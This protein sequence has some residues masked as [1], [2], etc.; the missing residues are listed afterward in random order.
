MFTYSRFIIRNTDRF[1]PANFPIQEAK[2]S[3]A[4]NAFNKLSS[5]YRTEM[6]VSFLKDHCIP[7]EWVAANRELAG[8]IS[9]KVLPLEDFEV[10]FEAGKDGPGCVQFNRKTL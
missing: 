9:S 8:M 3:F 1:D 4:K 5:V 10:L 7:S 2:I 6:L